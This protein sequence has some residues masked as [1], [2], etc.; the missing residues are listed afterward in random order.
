[1]WRSEARPHSE[2][3]PQGSFHAV[4]AQCHNGVACITPWGRDGNQVSIIAVPCQL[5]VP[6]AGGYGKDFLAVGGKE[7]GYVLVAVASGGHHDGSQSGSLVD[8]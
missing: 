1:V 7:A 3:H 2:G 5:P 4:H 8:G 6:L